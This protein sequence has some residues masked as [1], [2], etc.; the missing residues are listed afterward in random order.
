LGQLVAVIKTVL[1]DVVLFAQHASG[2]RLRSY[3][4]AVARAIVDSVIH[5]RG[6]AI[7]VMFP[8][9][10]GKNE[11]QAQ[12]E[13]YLLTLYSEIGGEI[14]KVS[15]TFKP[16]TINAMARLE[17]VLNGN[18]LVKERWWKESGYI[19][20]VGRA[21]CIFLSG[22]PKANIVGATASLLLQV[23]EAQDVQVSK[24]DKEVLPMVASTNATRVFWGTAWSGRT[25]LAR[26]LAAAREAEKRD[27]RKRVF[28]LT[29]DEVVK[30]VPAYGQFVTDQVEK[31][32]RDH[33]FVR[34]QLYSEEL[35]DGGGLFGVDRR[36]RLWG[37]HSWESGPEP[38]SLYALLIDVAGEDESGGSLEM[39]ARVE[40]LVNAGRDATAVTVVKLAP[41]GG[42]YAYEVV[43][44]R[45]WVG[46]KHAG[47]HDVLVCLAEFWGAR[48]VVVDNT[49]V[50]QGLWSFLEDA[51]GAD[52][53]LGFTF[54]STSKSKLGWQFLSVIETGRWR[55]HVSQGPD[56]AEF[57]RELEYVQYSVGTNESLRWSVPDGTRDERSGDLVHDDWVMSAALV[58][59]L[60]DM[61][62]AG[63][64]ASIVVR[65]RDVLDE[66]ISY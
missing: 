64:G 27:G 47:L 7:V 45:N 37:G 19:Y 15:P 28:V 33:P 22:G 65:A 53:V 24:F 23:D 44:R 56:Q 57:F 58:G 18:V 51:L 63:S 46:V 41:A 31:L 14:V 55:E 36:A 25:L 34:T 30:E 39:G 9:Q 32:G 5:R 62:V 40:S 20:G 61:P 35:Q 3:Q 16:Q 1:R 50:G 54:T 48:W 4:M 8:R 66:A 38:G 42:R 59:V 21:R 52:R 60:D 11:L 43:H 2:R 17:R 26:E 10:S 49:G 12:L 13:C 6:D 29:A